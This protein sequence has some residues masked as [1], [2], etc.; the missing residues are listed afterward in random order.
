MGFFVGSSCFLHSPLCQSRFLAS[1]SSSS[2]Q[3]MFLYSCTRNAETK[4]KN[5][6]PMASMHHEDPNHSVHLKRRAILFVGITVLPL[7]QL[8]ARA[9]EG[10][11]T[12][13]S[14][15]MK[16]EENQNAEMKSQLKE[17]EAAI[18]SLERNFESKLLKEQ[19]ERTKQLRK[20]KEEQQTL[21]SQ[22]NAANRTITGNIQN[23][24]SSLSEKELELNNLNFTYK[25]TKDE[26]AKAHSEIQG[27][28]GEYLK[29]QKELESKNSMVDELNTIVSSLTFERDDYK[30]KLDVIKEEYNDLKSSSE[31]KA[32]SDAK[33]LGEKEEELKRLKQKLELA[34]NEVSENQA[35]IAD[36]T[37]ER[38]SLRGTL[39]TEL[40]N[41]KHLKLE[42]QNSQEALGKCRN[43]VSDLT[44]QLKQ[45]INLCSELES[46]ISRVQAEF[47]E[48]REALQRSLDEA[49]LSSEVLAGEI[50]AV[51][52]VLKK[53]NEELQFVSHELTTTVEDRDRLQ[54]ELVGV[55]KK[56]ENVAN[57]LKEEKNV[58]S[59]LSKELQTLEKQILKDKE[60][61]R[62]L[63]TDLEE[64]T[65]SLDEMNR[66]V[67]VLSRDLE[68]ANSQI[69]DL[70]DEK[71]VLYKSLTEQKNVSREAQD[72][73]EDAHNL[74]M[75]LGKERE[76]LEKRAKKLEGELASAKG[77]ILRAR[78]HINSSKAHVNNQQPQQEEAEGNVA[79]T[80][81]KNVRRRKASSQ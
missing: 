21:L 55:Y 32:A 6:A 60:A 31:K 12:E 49:K 2:S 50:T 30:R 80:A 81:K 5:I 77:E 26:L 10:L 76:S 38:D 72:N 28:E 19:E 40:N 46:E 4:R 27:M 33:L 58:V 69:S 23:L 42:L 39:D 63:E 8:K 65:K 11:A 71:E 61:R 57:D 22:L 43:E 15:L 51:K 25:Q 1:S 67:F 7:L 64:A 53:T 68:K 75:R 62:S 13:E 56:A 37:Q 59:S 79:V 52:E 18:A 73:M 29:I 74:V 45:S 20:A 70:E 17:K 47:S 9:L 66:N 36:L 14:E 35:I 16:P 54:Q 78:S 3:P 44:S 24:R 48:V 41:V 34:L